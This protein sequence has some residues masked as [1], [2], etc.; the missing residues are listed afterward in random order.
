MNKVR[1]F[2]VEK[3]NELIK[4]KIRKIKLKLA[5]Y[6]RHVNRNL[7]ICLKWTFLAC[8][9]GIVVGGISTFFAYGMKQV[10]TI[11]EENPYL[12]YLLPI[13][14]LVIIFC[15]RGFNYKDDKGTNLVLSTVHAEAE[16]PARMAPLIFIS[17]IITHLFGGSAGREGAAL[18]LGGS[19]GNLIGRIFKLDDRDKRVI[20]MSGM[21]AA[22]AAVFGTPMAAAIFSIEVVSIGVM[23]YAALLPCVVAVLIASRF[24]LT[25]GINPETFTISNIPELSV[26]TG[27]IIFILA[28]FCAALSSLFCI[29]LHKVGK[30]FKKYIKNPYIRVFIAGVIVVIVTSIIGSYDYNGAGVDVIERAINGDVIWYAF[31]IKM[32]LTAITLQAGYKGGEIVPSFFIGA[33]FGALFGNIIGFSPSLCAGVGMM[34][35]FCGVTNCP[36]TTILISFEL[37]GFS[38]VSYFL[39]ATSVSYLLSGYYGLYKDQRIIYSKYKTRYI[40]RKTR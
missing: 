32:I 3:K 35:V 4:K 20:V 30:A 14:G 12:I 13:A 34:S 23:Y 15:Y 25:M 7:L 39:L 2:F 31:I 6:I 29:T 21:S 17:T 22:F 37:F 19:M 36:I 24:S 5:F 16:I 27:I 33:T 1:K 10:T 40:N 9:V 18:Q 11:R 26:K 38:G 8:V 28:I